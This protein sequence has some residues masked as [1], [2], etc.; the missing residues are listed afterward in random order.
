MA[1]AIEGLDVLVFSAGIGERSP[2]RR[3]RNDS[4]SRWTPLRTSA[5]ASHQRTGVARRRIRDSRRSGDRRGARD[6]APRGSVPAAESGCQMTWIKSVAAWGGHNDCKFTGGV[7]M[8]IRS[9]R[10]TR[11]HSTAKAGAA[12]GAAPAGVRP[13]A[14]AGRRKPAKAPAGKVVRKPA[15]QADRVVRPRALKALVPT[16]PSRDDPQG[17]ETPADGTRV[18]IRPI[19]KEDAAI[20][21]AFIKRLSPESR[22]MRFPGHASEP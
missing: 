3:H 14:K 2:R 13:A 11:R 15:R 19:H 20:E 7:V 5:T 22:R 6:R 16:G 12:S 1:A 8:A 17:M 4:G 21:R 10:S 18:L 9:T